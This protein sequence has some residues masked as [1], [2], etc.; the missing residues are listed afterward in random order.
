MGFAASVLPIGQFRGLYLDGVIV[1]FD[2]LKR[3]F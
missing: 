1:I 3:H 2:S